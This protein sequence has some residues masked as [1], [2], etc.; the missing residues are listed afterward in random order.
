MVNFL[1]KDSY[2]ILTLVSNL[3][4]GGVQRAA[5]NFADGYKLLGNDS[6]VLAANFGGSREENLKKLEIKFWIGFKYKNLSEIQTWDPDII[7]IHTNGINFRQVEDLKILC[8]N[9][10]FIE[11]NVFSKPSLW[12]E[13]LSLSF[14]MTSWCAWKY[15][16]SKDAKS[17][18]VSIAP[19]PV[20]TINFHPS[21]TKNIKDLKKKFNLPF[22]N[23]IIGRIG[24]SFSGKWSYLLIDTFNDICEINNN[25]NLLL[26]DPPEDIKVQA[27]KS[28]YKNKIIILDA[29]IGD[30]NLKDIYS[31][32]D[33]FALV[34]DQGESFGNVL[35]ESMLCKTPTIV[36]STP[37][38][39]NSQCEVIGHMQG[40]IVC[41]TPQGFKSGLIKLINNSTLRLKLGVK[42]RKRVIKNYDYR[43]VCEEIII[44]TFKRKNQK[45]KKNKLNFDIVSI[46]K[47]SFDNCNR[48]TIWLIK[49]PILISLTR[50]TSGYQNIF[51]FIYRYINLFLRKI[52]ILTILRR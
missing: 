34:A 45:R 28:K 50:L 30:E 18:I 32:L 27:K 40:G 25:I 47:D 29:I 52:K 10:I 22:E 26:V 6:R 20:K 37:W 14:Q 49:K 15:L 39:D 46:Y 9:S 44:K 7:H 41:V 36:L 5:T 17:E 31:L 3:E 38:G 21:N 13:Y 1:D 42:G 16:N 12:Q 33:I 4:K 24:Q 43:K 23:I 35:A 2:K 48:L 51:E 19:N 8:P 11:K